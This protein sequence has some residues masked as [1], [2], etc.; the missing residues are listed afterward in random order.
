MTPAQALLTEL[1]AAAVAAAD[2]AHCVPPCLPPPPRGRTAVLAFGKAAAS[3][4][5][6][7]ETHWPG[8]LEGLAVTRD[9]HGLPLHRI[10]L[11]F[12]GHP[13]GDTRSAQ[14]A[15]GML[16]LAATLGP[17]DLALVLVS[18]GGSALTTLP[19]PGIDPAS[20]AAVL[21]ALLHCG[22]PIAD[23]NSVRRRLSAFKGGRLAAAAAPA[24]VHSIVISDVP[25]DDPALVASGPSFPDPS[26]PQAAAAIL[27]RWRI[28]LPDDIARHLARPASPP[29]LPALSHRIAATAA[30]ALSAAAAL[31]TRRGL[32][33]TLLSDRLEGEART[34]GSAHAALARGLV[35]HGPQLLL[36]GGETS[37]TVTGSGRG[38]RNAEYLA[39]LALGIAG[40]PVTA[41]AADTDGIDGS[42]SNAGAHAD[43]TT[44][45][46]ARARGL[47]PAALLANNDAHALFAGLG[48]LIV[49]GPTRT[50]VNDFRA[51]LIES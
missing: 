44:L 4:A 23:I 37:V 35:G 42:E 28:P 50:N 7:V 40:L 36:S 19:A 6:A 27:A 51:I 12:A 43:G 15:R 29:V 47:D 20:K 18:G 30:S 5:A 46:R 8:P 25:G 14:A 45:A 24:R 16:D 41:L 22:A 33:C 32:R 26:P 13:H 9:G 1:F 34:L 11:L 17:D 10:R 38:G 3:M 2:P 31:A 39:A 21:R 48:D 49:T